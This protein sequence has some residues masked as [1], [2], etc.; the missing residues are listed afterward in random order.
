MM[1]VGAGSTPLIARP[2]TNCSAVSQPWA[3]TALSCR[4]G[5]TVYAPPNVTSPAFSPSPKISALSD[6]PC[7]GD[8]H[9]G[10]H[11]RFALPRHCS[12]LL[13]SS[14]ASPAASRTTAK[15]TDA[16]AVS[17]NEAA[18]ISASGMSVRKVRPRRTSARAMSAPTAALRP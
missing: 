3:S 1:M 2:S 14:Y 9:E 10:R 12:A 18:A 8:E 11:G 15:P 16:N 13:Q 17:A 6:T 7:R 4:N 5:I